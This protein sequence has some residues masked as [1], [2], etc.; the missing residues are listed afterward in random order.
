MPGW[1]MTSGV[2]VYEVDVMLSA[3]T[4]R[5]KHTD[6]KEQGAW[7]LIPIDRALRTPTSRAWR[8]A[9]SGTSV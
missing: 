8:S 7:L 2:C 6:L 3:D 9:P 1:E 4:G 5:E